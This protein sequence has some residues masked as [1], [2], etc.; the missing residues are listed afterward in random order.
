MR[1]VVYTIIAKFVLSSAHAHCTNWHSI[2][3]SMLLVVFSHDCDIRH[4]CNIL[5]TFTFKL[6]LVYLHAYCD[7]GH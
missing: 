5:L 6:I 1:G 3:H 4:T 7:T 2:V